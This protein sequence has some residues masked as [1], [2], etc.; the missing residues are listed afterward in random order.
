M[1]T[2]R[3]HAPAEHRRKRKDR[4]TRRLLILRHAKSDR[5]DSVSD[6]DRPLARRGEREAPL[7]GEHI[8][9]RGWLPDHVLSSPAVRARDTARVVMRVLGLPKTAI[10]FDERIYMASRA[11]L[12]RVLA[13][14][15]ADARTV[16]VIGHNPG[17]EELL[18]YLSAT[19]PTRNADGKLLTTSALAALDIDSDW[20]AV[21]RG[22]A[23][24]VELLPPRS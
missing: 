13:D 3:R 22:G 24:L 19:P 10:H 8:K 12:L 1:D 23:R 18:E 15:P 17:L 11:M 2:R 4:L 5:D 6:F 20:S 14:C 21:K 9:A 16:L 7:A